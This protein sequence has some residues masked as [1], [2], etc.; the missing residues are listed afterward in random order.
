M[1]LDFDLVPNAATSSRARVLGE[2]HA[3]RS[4][5]SS[6]DAQAVDSVVSRLA[7]AP[8]EELAPGAPRQLSVGEPVRLSAER[9]DATKL[10]RELC[11]P[12]SA[13]GASCCAT[14][15][16]AVP[17]DGGSMMMTFFC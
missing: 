11:G 14:L 15:Q 6:C 2:P 7:N 5:C 16:R 13:S 17:S 10:R 1:L 12:A 8:P 4:R 9:V 3:R